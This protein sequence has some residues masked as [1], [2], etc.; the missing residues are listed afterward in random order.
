MVG[1]LVLRGQAA[2]M[3]QVLPFAVVIDALGD[4]G[5][6]LGA[7]R[8][9]RLVGVQVEEL[10]PIVPEPRAWAVLTRAGCRMS[11]SGPIGRCARCWRRSARVAGGIALDD[12]HWADDA[13]LEL[14]AHL[15]RRPP[16]RGV[17]VVFAYRPAPARSVLV[18]ALARAHLMAR[19]SSCHSRR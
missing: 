19:W 12:L 6:S 16:R 13:S 5:A 9:R 10:A 3:E 2:E 18:D 4:F 1:H 11:G 7:D 14:I 8:L 15:L 17:M